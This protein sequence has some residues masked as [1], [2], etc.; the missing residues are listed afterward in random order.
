MSRFLHSRS[1]PL[2]LGG[3]LMVVFG[4]LV[5]L[6]GFTLVYARGTSYLSDDPNACVNCHVMRDQFN[7]WNKSSHKAVAACNDCHM[8]HDTIAGKWIT[9]AINGFNHSFAFTTGDYPATITIK[10]NNAD[11]VQKNCISCHQ[12]LVTQIYSAHADRERRCVD[13]HGNVGHENRSTQ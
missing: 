9:K 8:P 5:G 10:K 3:L 7:A 4:I 12:T 6:G 1:M 2:L 11:I 13:C